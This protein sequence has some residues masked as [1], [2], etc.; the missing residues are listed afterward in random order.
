MDDRLAERLEDRQG[1]LVGRN[2]AADHDRER[3]GD[4]ALVAA[5]HR[6]VEHLGPGGGSTLRQLAG[7][8]R[9]DRAHVDGQPAGSQRLERAVRAEVDLANLGRVGQHRDQDVGGGRDLGRRGAGPR[10]LG[11]QR[12]HG[13]GVDV[14]DG[15]PVARLQQ[16]A[17]H[18]PAHDPEADQPERQLVVHQ[19]FSM[20]RSAV[21]ETGV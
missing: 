1:S 12:G 21:P 7:S 6:R 14:E 18:G 13:R 15:Q 8:A 9:G 16:V 5:A 3:A 2:A 17:G 19:R 4:G 20:P 11:R 10:A